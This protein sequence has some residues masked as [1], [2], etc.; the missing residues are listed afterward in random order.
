MGCCFP[1]KEAYSVVVSFGF[2]F[3]RTLQWQFSPKGVDLQL[4]LTLYGT[5]HGG[6]VGKPETDSLNFIQNAAKKIIKKKPHKQLPFHLARPHSFKE[7]GG[8]FKLLDGCQLLLIFFKS[9]NLIFVA[10]SLICPTYF[11]AIY[12]RHNLKR[13]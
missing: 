12:K 2:V 3:C 4:L 10:G 1:G 9:L 13:I 7:G 8:S 11:T 6:A 5:L